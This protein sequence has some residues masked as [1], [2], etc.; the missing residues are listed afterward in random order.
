MIIFDIMKSSCNDEGT[1]KLM[2]Y[3]RVG[4]NFEKAEE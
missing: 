1:M 2:V 3:Q 4:I